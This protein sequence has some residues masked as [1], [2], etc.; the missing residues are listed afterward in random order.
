VTGVGMRARLRTLGFGLTTLLGR[1]PR[2]F[3]LPYRYAASTV[4]PSHY[5]E[6]DSVFRAAEPAFRTVLD[7]I[8]SHAAALEAIGTAPPPAPR[9]RQ[10]WFPRMDAAAA[11]AIVR[12]H[13]PERIVEVGSGHSTR[14]MARAVADGSLATR[15]V[16]VDPAPRAAIEG[17]ELDLRRATLQSVLDA[18]DG[19]FRFGPRDVLFID[20]SHLLVAG[21]DVDLLLNRLVPRLPSGALLHV[22]D[23]FLPDGYPRIWGWRGYNEQNALAPLLGYGGFDLVFASRW[24]ATRMASR[25]ERSVLARLPLPAGA[26]ET[27]LW[28]RRR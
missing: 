6:L 12:R 15:I 17:L 26:W 9:W 28:L 10:D 20:S 3:F 5:P 27:S 14:F 21:S 16:A 11:Y 8:E 18:D 23:I 24:A 1:R 7:D 22:H 19:L 2:G 4:A 13:R 25:I